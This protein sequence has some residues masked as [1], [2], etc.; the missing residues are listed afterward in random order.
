M[1][2][3]LIILM[4]IMLIFSLIACQVDDPVDDPIDD[5]IDNPI[6]DPIDD[7]VDEPTLL[8]SI[9]NNDQ[10][11]MLYDSDIEKMNQ[12]E[13]T[14]YLDPIIKK[15]YVGYLLSELIVLTDVQ[16]VQIVSPNTYLNAQFDLNQY[17][18][19]VGEKI[20]DQV[21]PFDLDEYKFIQVNDDII[22]NSIDEPKT[23]MI[24]QFSHQEPI[25]YIKYNSV[26]GRYDHHTALR[27]AQGIINR[28]APRLLTLSNSNPYF[29][30]SD[31]T[32]LH[33]LEAEGYQLIEL[34]SLEEVFFTFKDTFEGIITFKDR[35]KSYNGWV[36]AE[37]D[38]AL[39]FASIHNFAAVPK[40]LENTISELTGLEIISTFEMNGHEVLG[41]IS[42]Y[43]D[44]QDATVAYDVY[45]HMFMNFKESFNKNAYMSLTSEVMD[46]AASE[47]MMFF[48]LK[49]TQSER[50]NVLSKEINEYF[51]DH[52]LYFEVYGWV[53][54]ESSALDFISKYGGVIDVVGNGNLSLL[55]RLEVDTE[56]FNQPE[57][58]PI[59]YDAN[60]KYVTFF[61]S[62]SD[63]IKVGAAFQH[64]AWLD[65][66]RGKVP[67][68]WGLIADMS[69]EFRFVYD[70]FMKTATPNDYFYSGGGSAVGFV[71]IDT[72]MKSESRDAIADANA[73]YLDLADQA[74]IDMYNDRYTPTDVFDK[75]T[76][77]IYL[78][79]SQVDG[80]FARIHDGNTSIRVEKWNTVPVYN[81]WTN[82][83][84]RR[85][86]SGHVNLLVLDQL[87][88][89]LYE[90]THQS[91]YWFIES[92]LTNTMNSH[93]LWLFSNEEGEGYK[94]EFNDGKITLSKH[95][96][97][98][99][100]ILYEINY[101][102]ASRKIKVSIDKSTPLDTYVRIKLYI[103]DLKIIEVYDNEDVLI[104]GGFK[105]FSD[106]GVAQTFSN[107]NGTKYSMAQAIYRRIIQDPNR[108][109]LAYYGFVGT[110]E[111][112]K[113]QYRSEPG[114][115]GVI[116]L[117]PTDFYKIS[118]LLALNYP[119]VYEIVLAPEF[120]EFA[121]TYQDYYGTLR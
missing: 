74:Y 15:T 85:G 4:T 48:D 114:I 102:Q 8:L 110:E 17:F 66:N 56:S 100:E 104:S 72:Q 106:D 108:F 115:G 49:A 77:G 55:S 30:D 86:S 107:V 43:L 90:Q 67:I 9:M 89:E 12:I 112:T 41:N 93:G 82:F 117:S 91:D 99:V 44:Q 18:Y 62:E 111:Y 118:L 58:N 40:G 71:D 65:P 16:S 83:Y 103:N 14:V 11:T 26:T 27:A 116:S 78:F 57:R 105:L 101:H 21:Q 109:I 94:I 96:D 68:N 32:W 39:M 2:K 13:K 22:I 19:V 47:K 3:Y 25:Y 54:Q 23:I 46:Y 69:E 97:D 29:K 20:N 63:T 33:I 52:N 31:D 42:D 121:T 53:D 50:D 34:N 60:K 61:A 92:N 88:S 84:P 113:A 73:F 28:E 37:S 5:P 95:K 7:P 119:D 36:S 87:S 51:D 81:R 10:E 35:F 45:E 76:L 98:Q 1:K 6:D 75:T 38:A 80:A 24:N 120:L 70:Y 64:G 79:R 59:T